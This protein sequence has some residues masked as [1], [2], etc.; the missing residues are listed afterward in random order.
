MPHPSLRRKGFQKIVQ[1]GSFAALLALTL[2]ISL[3]PLSVLAEAL[4]ALPE[5]VKKEAKGKMVLLDFYSKFCGT[6]QMM[7][8]KLKAL[9]RQTGD[10]VLFRHVNVE[11]DND[12]QLAKP[13]NIHGTPTYVLYSAEGKPVYRMQEL[14]IPSVLQ[15][16]VLRQTGDL[17]PIDI[18]Q[19]VDI[20]RL[21][22]GEDSALDQLILLS[23]ETENC[24]ECAEMTPYLQGFEISGQSNLK[25][26]RLNTGTESAKK[27]MAQMHIRKAPS[28]ALLDNSMVSPEN[29]AN[30]RRNEL[31]VFRGN[32]PPRILWDMIRKISESGV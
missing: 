9:Q 13:F 15:V 30:N 16:Q 5:T 18:P 27:L 23:F 32:V 12:S 2:L 14:I 6:C 29:L 28:Y 8:P 20:P 22:L 31:F 1:T 24:T 7:E 17:R 4:P 26:L 3:T 10:K 25:V 19:D 11:A 21:T